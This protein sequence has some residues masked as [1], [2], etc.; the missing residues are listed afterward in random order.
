MA[1]SHELRTPLTAVAGYAEALAD[2]A[3]PA[4]QVAHAGAVIRNEAARLE[5]RVQDLLA[6]ARLDADEFALVRAPTDVAALLWAAQA[7]WRPQA[8]RAGV[9]LSVEVAMGLPAVT[10]DGERLRQAVDALVDNALRVLGPG[11][12][13]VL[14][15]RPEPGAAVRV[16]VRDGGPGISP[17]D[18]AVAF[19]RGELAERYRGTRP[20]GSGLG[21][22]LV[23]ELAHRLGGWA[24]ATAAPEGGAAFAVVLP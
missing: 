14:A 18:L 6:L 23:G 19:E 21:L 2:G 20:V 4:E 13:L 12:P 22:A 1:V 5:H 16:E 17:Q 8:E 9:R 24:E 7:A 3:L 15:A 11:A 10:T